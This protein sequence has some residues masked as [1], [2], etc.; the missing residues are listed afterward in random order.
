[1]TDRPQSPD[2]FLTME[3]L[4]RIHPVSHATRWRMIEKGTFPKPVRI[5]PGRVAWRES[6]VLAWVGEQK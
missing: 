3:E 2:R 1:M 6:A 4:D 5:S